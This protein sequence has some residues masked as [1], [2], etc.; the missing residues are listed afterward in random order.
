MLS[1]RSSRGDPPKNH[2]FRNFVLSSCP[3]VQVRNS[4]VG[5]ESFL[6][7]I[8]SSSDRFGGVWWWRKKI[9]WAQVP[10]IGLGPGSEIIRKSLKI[11]SQHVG[12]TAWYHVASLFCT[13]L[14]VVKFLYLENGKLVRPV[15]TGPKPV[16]ASPTV[17]TGPRAGKFDQ[18]NFCHF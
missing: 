4:A 8:A 18:K 10:G 16:L 12:A 11:G 17:P 6:E 2:A 13:F 9:L 14:H 3:V 1:S 5:S 15:P 7:G